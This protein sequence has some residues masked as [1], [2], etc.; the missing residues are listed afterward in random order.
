MA[1]INQ[2][3]LLAK[4]NY[5]GKVFVTSSHKTGYNFYAIDLYKS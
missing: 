3:I 4:E 2:F 5:S 1:E